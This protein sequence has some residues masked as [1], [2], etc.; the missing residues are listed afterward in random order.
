VRLASSI[1]VALGI[2]VLFACDPLSADELDCEEAVSVLEHCCPGFVGSAL[3]CVETQQGCSGGT[4][5]ALSTQDSAC[6]RGESCAELVST[7][8]CTRAQQA[9]SCTSGGYDSDG[10]PIGPTCAPQPTA[11]P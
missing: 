4:T 1:V 7:S 2:G 5:P 9:R 10:N 3:S 8:V 11:C 6:I